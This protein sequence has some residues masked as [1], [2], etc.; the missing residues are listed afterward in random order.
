MLSGVIVD[1]DLY[2][3]PVAAAAI[4]RC[5]ASNLMSYRHTQHSS[6]PWITNPINR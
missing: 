4:G 3:V 1:N 5:D 6:A 2:I